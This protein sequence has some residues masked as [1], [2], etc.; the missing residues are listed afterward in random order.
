MSPLPTVPLQTP[1]VDELNRLLATTSSEL[2]GCM[3]KNRWDPNASDWRFTRGNA[4]LG[5]LGYKVR[6]YSPIGEF[7]IYIRHGG[8][9]ILLFRGGNW[10]AW[11]KEDIHLLLALCQ[12]YTSAKI[13]GAIVLQELDSKLYEHYVEAAPEP[14]KMVQHALDQWRDF[15]RISKNSPRSTAYCPYCPVKAR[16]DAED[17]ARGQTSDWPKGYQVGDSR[18]EGSRP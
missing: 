16:C 6:C 4:V 14:E 5:H 3:R 1:L 17:L 10:K 8:E 7:D 13:K 15:A 12:L 2:I 9:H 18:P 11:W